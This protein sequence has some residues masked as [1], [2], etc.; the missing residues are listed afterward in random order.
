MP[1]VS[2]PAVFGTMR[3]LIA[4]IERAKSLETA[5]STATFV[6]GARRTS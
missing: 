5:P 3:M 4:F 2:R 1:T 6:P